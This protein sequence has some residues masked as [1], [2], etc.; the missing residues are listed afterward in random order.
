VLS[1]AISALKDNTV[2]SFL[3]V[4]GGWSK[5]GQIS[6]ANW[7]ATLPSFN[8]GYGNGGT[9]FPYGSLG[10]FELNGTLSNP[11]LRPEITKEFE[12]GVEMSFIRNRFHLNLN[13]YQSRTKDQTIPATI[14]YATGYGSAFINAGE[15]QTQGIETDFKLT[16]LLNFGDFDWNLTINYTYQTSKVLSILPGLDQLAITDVNNTG[17]VSYAVVGQQFPSILVS[18]VERDPAGH[19]IVDPS[20]GY[21]IKDPSLKNLGHGNPNHLL[22]ITNNFSYKGLNLNVVAEYRTG[23]VIYNQV[24][25]QLDFTGATWHTAQNGRQSFVVP[26]SV[27]ANGDGTFTPNT[28]VVVK[29]AGHLFWTNSDY[30]AVQSTYVTSAA[31]WKLREVS[32]S[33][34]IPVSNILGGKITAAQIGIVG[35]NLIMLRPKTNIWTDP[36]FNNQG[37]TSNAVGNTDYNQ[38]PPTRVYG[39]S[40][41]LTF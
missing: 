12:A 11:N 28:N 7:Y 37:G 18:D 3:K 31:F 38:T 39:F 33:Y 1:D 41:K 25:S 13:G 35:R 16:P 5:T 21:P 4:R 2:L 36:E 22:G 15:L 6:L 14:S 23:N 30:T 10:G 27:L 8:A 40:V 26:N 29:N 32:L 19:I 17:S 24:G 9:G 34:D 20:T